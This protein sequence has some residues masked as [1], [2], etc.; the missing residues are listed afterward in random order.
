MTLG[1]AVIKNFSYTPIFFG[2]GLSGLVFAII[3]RDYFLI[4]W[5]IP[6]LIFLYTIGFVRDFHL[7]P[8]LP[9]LCMSASRLIVGLS[10]YIPYQKVR[11]TL[12]F[13]IISVIAIFGLVNIVPPLT[14]NGMN[15]NDNKFAL[16]AFVTRYLE[17]NRNENITVISSHVYSWIPKYVFGL[18]NIDYRI[19]DDTTPPKNE[20]VMLVVDGS[21]RYVTS[22]NNTYGE[23]LRRTHNLYNTNETVKVDVGR[24]KVVLPKVWFSDFTRQPEMELI[25]DK[26]SWKSRKDAEVSQADASLIIL[27]KTNS[28]EKTTRHAI[29][30]T[31]LENFTKSPLLLLLEYSAKSS[32]TNTTYFIEIREK[33]ATSSNNFREVIFKSM[34]DNTRG[35]ITK[36]LFILPAE[37]ADRPVEF[38]LGI[39]SNAPGE[40]K[41]AVK[42]ASIMLN[43]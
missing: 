38:R 12:S 23:S 41:L 26:H 2:L 31:E 37:I 42:R 40:H 15:E 5:A 21:F 24:D 32:K 13:S 9:A 4:L 8:L 33:D 16:A 22:L 28:T 39:N 18:G 1:N 14:M 3:K 17:D 36:R 34:L 27:S 35:Y 29:M 30:R 11:Q 20:K 7:I 10:S 6:F 43:I 19:P 25:S